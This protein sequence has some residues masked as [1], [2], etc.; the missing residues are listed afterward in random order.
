MS[1][2]PDTAAI[3]ENISSKLSRYFGCTP[4]EASREQLY[5]AVVMTVKDILTEKRGKF[6]QEVNRV[7]AKRVYYMS[8]EFLPGRSLKNNL[9]N[10][11]LTESYE[12]A[13]KDFGV[14]LEELFEFEP[15]AALGNGGL[16]RLASCYLDSLTSLDYPVTGYSLCYQYGLFRQM[17]VDGT[18]VELP[19]TWL[20]GGEAWLVPRA[21]RILHVKMGGRVKENW[22]GS[23]LDISYEDFE[24]IEAVPYD[25]IISG[26]NGCGANNLRLFRARDVKNFNMKLFTQ[27]QY[28]MAVKENTNAE[29]ITKVLYPSDNH[30]EGK[31]LRLSQQYFLVSAAVQ[32][33]LRDHVAVHGTPENLHEKAAIH[34]NDT[35]TAMCI[36]E[37][38]RILTDEYAFPWEK[39]FDIAQKTCS[40]TNHTVM[41]EALETWNEDLFRLRLPR[42]YTIIKEINERFCTSAFAACDGN[43]AKVSRMSIIAYNQIRMANLCIVGSHMTNGVSALHSDILKKSLFKDFNRI[44]PERFTNVTNGIAY[45]RWLCQ[46]NPALSEL[47]REAIGDAF[48]KE[49]EQLSSL[50]AYKDDT[51]FLRRLAEIKKKNKTA[52]AEKI[53]KKSGAILNADSVFDVQ[54]KRIHE[55]KRQL[56][57]ALAIIGKYL[58]IL[59]DPRA[60]RTPVTYLFAG[61]SAPGYV[62]AKKII[63]LIYYVGREI[64]A[65]PARELLCVVFLEDYNVSL[66]ESII[67]AAEISE[68]ISLAGKEASGTGC[69]KL[70][71]NGALTIGTL[72]GANIEIYERV[73]SENMYIFGLNSEE[74]DRLWASGYYS[75][76]YFNTNERLR[77]VIN[78]LNT[79]FCGESF[80]DIASYLVNGPGVPDPFMCFADF[81][82]YRSTHERALADYADPLKWNRSSLVNIATSGFF[83]AERAVSEYAEKIWNIKSVKLT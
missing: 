32:S 12:A 20:S 66:A 17:I 8:M 60:C 49:P 70:M 59:E 11:S 4:E 80:S 64:A 65:S 33:I 28:A 71:M 58:D 38:I 27:G 6:K 46:A 39:A 77:R 10:L 41:P 56:M 51:A 29:I 3:R 37:L 26:K 22:T 63:K 14:S 5:K 24:E 62:M 43:F 35:H 48:L 45:R 68:Q 79:G 72:D 34:I 40:Y 81:E 47:I 61:K 9:F 23:H 42:I 19:D 15:D 78:K 67:P 30:T 83:A 74:V 16:G 57:N 36:P 13:L 18:Q 1:I 82:S 52:L 76:T 73:G 31:L 53:A 44:Y 54:I 75:Q 55:Y 7:R 50:L 69:M 21:D 2:M 25:L